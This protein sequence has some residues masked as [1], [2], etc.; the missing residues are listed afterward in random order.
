M[1][2]NAWIVTVWNLGSSK[3]TKISTVNLKGFRCSL[4]H[5]IP[6]SFHVCK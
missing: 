5:R 1:I 2:T 3:N 4:P 6:I